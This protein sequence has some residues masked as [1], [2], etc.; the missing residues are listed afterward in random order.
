MNLIAMKTASVA[1][2][3]S[4]AFSAG[5]C[6]I[7]DLD[8]SSCLVDFS[9][10]ET[11]ND[12]YLLDDP[13]V[14]VAMPFALTQ[15]ATHDSLRVALKLKAVG[16]PTGSLILEIQADS[17]GS[18]SNLAIGSAATLSATA[19]STT[20]S[21]FHAFAFTD[22]KTLAAGSYWIVLR[23][24]GVSGSNQILWM[25][26]DQG[27]YGGGAPKATNNPTTWSASTTSGRAFLFQVGCPV[28]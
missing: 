18:P 2:V 9:Q 5:G 4:L 14:R 24:Q 15:A 21:A 10:G 17:S 11:S 20:V 27:L 22:S 1:L 3:L 23:A 28:I 25:G 13:N 7:D 8:D 16:S 12:E 6:T 19:V 26:N